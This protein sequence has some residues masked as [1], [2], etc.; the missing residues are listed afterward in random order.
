MKATKKIVGATAALVAAVALSAGS[1]FAWFAASSTATIDGMSVSVAS[2]NNLLISQSEGSGFTGAL[3]LTETTASNIKPCSTDGEASITT[4]SYSAPDFYELA[5][6]GDITADNGALTGTS[7]VKKAEVTNYLAKD[8]YI[9][10]SGSAS[11]NLKL[12]ISVTK[13]EEESETTEIDKSLRVLLVVEQSDTTVASYIYAPVTGYDSTVKP[14]IGFA[15]E[16]TP[17]TESGSA[18]IAENAATISGNDDVV[19]ANLTAD[20][21]YTLHIYIWYEGQDAACK[22]TNT[23]DA[24]TSLIG[25]TFTATPVTQQG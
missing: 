3:T 16:G 18:T 22:A 5:T 23:V 24:T 17:D 25:L 6:E 11:T 21:V 14:V 20:T 19:L 7:T 2:S 8:L 9:M 1:T 12:S 10:S 13:E 15:G 4:G